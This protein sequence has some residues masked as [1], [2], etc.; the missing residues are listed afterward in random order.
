M[1]SALTANVSASLPITRQ[2]K[3]EHGHSSQR[4]KYRAY[5]VNGR[6]SAHHGFTRW[7]RFMR[8]M[9][10]PYDPAQAKQLRDDQGAF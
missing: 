1:A 8:R 2:Q 4:E 7:P 9:A 5:G 6:G 3:A 10:A